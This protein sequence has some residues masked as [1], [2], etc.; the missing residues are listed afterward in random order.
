MEGSMSEA[1]APERD[2]A[3]AGGRAAETIA[4]ASSE[5]IRQTSEQ[6][7]ARGREATAATA[8][9]AQAA[10]LTGS[11]LAEGLQQFTKAWTDYAEEMMRQTSE[12]SRAL[13]GCR[14]LGEMYEIQSGLLRGNLQA[15]LDQS[16]R[17]AEI[18]VRLAS[19]PFDAWK[20][21]S[22]GPADR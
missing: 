1:K 2:S 21:V 8:S 13:I 12:A 5:V 7:S 4:R 10:M 6:V 19:Q 3:E 22:R 16:G 17:I 20:E 9:A 18:T 15:F 11:S 14:S